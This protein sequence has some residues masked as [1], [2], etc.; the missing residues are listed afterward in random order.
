M[1]L[2]GALPVI[3]NRG[4]IFG[5]RLAING[6]RDARSWTVVPLCSSLGDRALP[7]SLFLPQR[8]ESGDPV[9]KFFRFVSFYAEIEIVSDTVQKV[10]RAGLPETVFTDGFCDGGGAVTRFA[11]GLYGDVK[12]VV[13]L[14]ADQIASKVSLRGK[15]C[16]YEEELGCYFLWPGLYHPLF[17]RFLAPD[18]PDYLSASNAAGLNPYAYCYNDPIMYADPT[19]H[20]PILLVALIWMAVGAFATAGLELGKQLIKNGF[21]WNRL[22]W[23]AIGRQAF[24]GGALGFAG[25]AGGAVLGGFLAGSASVSEAQVLVWFGISSA[26]SF[27]GGIGAYAVETYGRESDWD[28]GEALGSGFAGMAAGMFAYGAGG[29]SKLV[30]SE[31]RWIVRSAV[32][33]GVKVVYSWPLNF[34]ES[35]LVNYLS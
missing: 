11:Y 26:V 20:L 31:S 29:I 15:A 24:I 18:S 23:V 10:R 5:G 17:G 33:L 32:Q 28:W 25:G 1:R 13:D 6:P 12:S 8:G 3:E 16:P 35:Q 4:S 9:D 19:G 22:D 14:S 21:D 7:I 30:F 27:A 2:I 34:L